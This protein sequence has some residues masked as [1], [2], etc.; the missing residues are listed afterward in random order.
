MLEKSNKLFIFRL[1]SVH[2]EN[3][4]GNYIMDY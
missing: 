3:D 2:D 1:F 4:V